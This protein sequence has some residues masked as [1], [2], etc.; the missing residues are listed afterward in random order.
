MS[1]LPTCLV[2]RFITAGRLQSMPTDA[3]HESVN[4]LAAGLKDLAADVHMAELL[5]AARKADV[6]N[7]SK[8]A[9]LCGE[10][11][12]NVRAAAHCFGGQF[13]LCAPPLWLAANRGDVEICKVLLRHKAESNATARPC[14]GGGRACNIGGQTPLH[15]A[16]VAG[17][18]ECVEKLLLLGAAADTP[19]CFAIDE[20]DEPEWDESQGAFDNG[21]AGTS[22]LQAAAYKSHRETCSLLLA[23]GATLGDSPAD[24]GVRMPPLAPLLQPLKCAGEDEALECPICL[25]GLTQL[26]S[27]W[28]PCCLRAFHAHCISGLD[29]CPL[30]RHEFLLDERYPGRPAGVTLSQGASG[31]A[32]SGGAAAAAPISGIATYG[33]PSAISGLAAF[34][35]HYSERSSDWYSEEDR[36][37]S[38]SFG[39]T[40]AVQPAWATRLG[41]AGPYAGLLAD[42]GGTT[43]AGRREG[44]GEAEWVE[45]SQG[46]QAAA[47]HGMVGLL[48]GR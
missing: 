10:A 4:R 3:L 13:C 16:V 15:L 47:R 25:S 7:T 42:L 19:M 21:L 23:N 28:T 2:A 29:K 8:Y 41:G 40:T 38:S 22:A 34:E 27:M 39:A 43:R 5:R 9:Q 6:A 1:C 12:I 44:G 20:A 26:G 14:T 45:H 35:A 32:R 31:A 48:D 46:V 17:S 30:C 37:R 33:S 18:A 36:H 24:W 11:K